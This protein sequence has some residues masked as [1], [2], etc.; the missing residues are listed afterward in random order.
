MKPPPMPIWNGPEYFRVTP[1]IY[2]AY[3]IRFQGPEWVRSYQRWSLMIEFE[4]LGE[5]E[6]VRVCLFLN[7]GRDQAKP[8][9]GRRSNYFAAWTL[10]NGGLPTRGQA[11]DPTV[12]LE[13][14]IYRVEVSDSL[15]DSNDQE[16]PQSAVYSKV[17]RIVSAER[18]P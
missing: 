16:K 4:L 2:D 6:R 3:S 11:M 1:G 14:Q 15:K 13:S 7:L 17:T 5:P 9:I 12:F 18:R 10:A 8:T